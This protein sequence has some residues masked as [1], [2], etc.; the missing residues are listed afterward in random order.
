MRSLLR[1]VVLVICLALIGLAPVRAEDEKIVNVYNWTDYIAPDTVEKF[2]KET[3]I[4]VVYDNYDGNE[5]L[6]TKLLAGRSGYDVVYPSA[7]PFLRNQVKAETLQPL[8]RDAMP[9]AAKV[10]PQVLTLI[11]QADPGNQHAMPYMGVTDGIGYNVEA[12]KRRMPDAP[13]DS[14]AMIFD[15][16]IV[17]R[18]ADC[19]VAMID[20]PTEVIPMALAYLKLDPHSTAPGDLAKAEALLKKV[21]PSIRYFHS[22]RYINDLANGDICLALGWSGDIL[23]AK[24]R[25]AAAAKPVE[26]AYA[27][28]REGT[29]VNFDTMAVPKDAPHPDNA[30][31]WIDFNL[32][33][34][35]AA[36]NSNF[37]S[38]ANAVP[39]ARPLL[40]EAIA[41]DPGIYP[42]DDVKARL[43]VV[44]NSDVAVLRRQTRA[45]TRI[46]TGQ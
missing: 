6:E 23:Q 28:P 5:M 46:L 2:Q 26:V 17:Q 38:Y 33:P 22:S 31:R 34:D 13:V 44:T 43:F 39:A 21:R 14:F 35:I 25:G 29:L 8:R 15:P 30:M 32:R 16:A 18:F 11:A 20:A 9:N 10:D 41:K 7:F 12:I 40:T 1:S 27:I 37:I 45:W 19:G 3:G 42:P 36:A 4:K 24:T